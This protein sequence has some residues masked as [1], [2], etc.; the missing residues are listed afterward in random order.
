V[1]SKCSVYKLIELTRGN[2][3]FDL[4]I[5]LRGV[6]EL[7]PL[8]ECHSLLGREG[9]DFALEFLKLGHARIIREPVS[10]G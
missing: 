2:V 3:K 4:T 8:A 10:F 6:V 7:K 9:F 1:V 5:P